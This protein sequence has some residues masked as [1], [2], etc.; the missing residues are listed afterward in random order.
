[1]SDQLTANFSGKG[2][3]RNLND[4]MAN[5][6]TFKKCCTSWLTQIVTANSTNITLSGLGTILSPLTANVDLSKQ[7]GNNLVIN[8]DG[9]LYFETVEIV[10]SP[11]VAALKSKIEAL[12]RTNGRGPRNGYSSIIPAT[13]SPT[14]IRYRSG[15]DGHITGSDTPPTT[16]IMAPTLL[17][18]RC[19]FTTSRH[20]TGRPRQSMCS[21][22]STS[23]FQGPC[24]NPGD[25][26]P[27]NRP[28]WY[29][30][31]AKKFNSA[32]DHRRPRSRGGGGRRHLRKASLER[33]AWRRG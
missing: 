13:A 15:L 4:L 17:T 11:T 22:S 14:L 8:S 19:P 21:W 2:Y 33:P 28:P 32:L 26:T 27:T 3:Q 10:S 1:M 5:L 7:S 12:P 6:E 30:S 9:Q 24:S 20:G 31:N 16:P 23:A 18:T 25:R 29:P